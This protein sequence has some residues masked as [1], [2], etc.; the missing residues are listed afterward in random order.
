LEQKRHLIFI[1]RQF[2]NFSFHN[3]KL[4]KNYGTLLVA[5]LVI[6]VL[7]V[8]N[9]LVAINFCNPQLLRCVVCHLF[10]VQVDVGNL[11]QEKHKGFLNYNKNHGTSS[12]KIH[13]Y[14][15]HLEVYRKW[16]FLATNNGRN[17]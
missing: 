15:E 9:G 17:Y 6:R 3:S 12:L 8:I 13:A 2:G 10:I 14:N 16:G 1:W 4:I 11:S 5:L 7:F